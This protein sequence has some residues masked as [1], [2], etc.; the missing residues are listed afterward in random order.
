MIKG[1]KTY[2]SEKLVNELPKL[3][4]PIFICTVA[5]TKTSEIP[6]ITGAGATPE[7]TKFTPTG[8]AELIMSGKVMCMEDIPQT[9]IGEVVT[10]TPSVLTKASVE[11]C[12]S[13]KMIIDAGCEIKAGIDV[14]DISEGNF[15]Q[16][17]STGKAVKDPEAIFN[18]AYELGA[19]LSEKHDYIVIGESLPAGTTT[20]LGVLV[21]LGYNAKGKVS[22]C[23]DTNPHEM[24]N[25][26]VDEGL[27]KAGLKVDKNNNPFDVVAAVG[28]P[29]LPAVAGVLMGATVPVVLAGGTQLTA[30]CAIAKAIDK[31]FDFSNMCLA[32]TAYVVA[33]ETADVLDI[34]K[35]IGDITVCAVNPFF[36]ESAVEG[37]KNY[38]KGFIK[39][40]AGA[41][42]AMFLALMRGY[43]IEEIREAIEKEALK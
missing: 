29:M 42:G 36:E 33:D 12:N 3:K 41:G 22:G 30:S 7:L 14:F 43:T 13:T 35:Q 8:D 40:G 11:L 24:K 17:I 25:K 1:L 9:I 20:A 18:K 28:D 34:A 19:I 39:E 16:D 27:E 37:L 15:G 10:P 38:T 4:N 32:T 26:V 2:G 21:G 31:D 6:G 23:M 5:S